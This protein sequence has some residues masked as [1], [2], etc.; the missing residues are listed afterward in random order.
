M[1]ILDS[2]FYGNT[3]Q[4]WI[5]ALALAATVLFALTIGKA[6]FVGKLAVL[7]EKTET[8]W[9][10][11]AV[12][13]LG[14]TKFFF[15]F[16][17]A[18]YM[19][20]VVVTLPDKTAVLATKAV[21]I[22]F[23]IQAAIWGDALIAHL[24]TRFVKQKAE[25]DAAGATTLAVLGFIARVFVWSAV[26][27]LALDNLGF[28]ITALV[29]GLGI[30]GIAAA[31]AA[32]NVLGDLFASIAIV[33][34]KPFV[35]GDFI[36]VGDLMGTV[37]QV[38]LK[39]TRV[40]SL[41]GEQLIFSNNDLLNSRIR[42]YKRM[43]ERRILFS[44]G[45]V[46][47][48]PYEKLATIP[49]TIR[50]IIDAQENTRFDRAHFKSYGDFALNFEIVYYVKVPEYNVYMDIQQAINFTIFRRFQEEGIEFAYPTQSLYLEKG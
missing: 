9:D 24:V 42:N 45:V 11:I 19:G 25:R 6:I 7:A 10:D 1:T 32:Q 4:L 50:E 5:A 47:H 15:L 40:R 26:V 49:A 18:L 3:V 2:T 22:A 39:T 27:L 44:I 8:Q 41:Y 46:Y 13:L 38:G 29:A 21:V 12:D 43:F 48:T 37:E 33:L 28:D 30:G 36:I 17:I 34:D 31:L 14:R 23:L 35:V 16:F 20:S